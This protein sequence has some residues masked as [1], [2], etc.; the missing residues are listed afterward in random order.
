[1]DTQR[2]IQLKTLDV[3]DSDLKTLVNKLLQYCD[4]FCIELTTEQAN[5]CVEHLLYVEQ[6][7]HYINLTRITNLDEALVL[8]ILDSLA[9]LQSLPPDLNSFLDMGTGPGFPGVPI[10]IATGCNGILLDSVGKKVNVVNAILN[11]LDLKTLKAV[12]ERTELFASQNH[13]FDC[14]VARA[15]GPIPLLL[16]YGRPFLQLGSFLVI[17]KANPSEGELSS[18]EKVAE[19]LGLELD[20]FDE[21]DLPNDLGHRVVYTYM[22][23]ER[24]RVKLPRTPGLAK[25]NPLA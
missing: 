13:C 18:G 2:E 21:F 4:D 22:A 23:V 17:A 20:G 12:H 5:L 10:G 19:M 25:K 7:N 14:V 1:M 16:E 6:V 9:L 24:S 15:L 11:Q 8:H 3:L